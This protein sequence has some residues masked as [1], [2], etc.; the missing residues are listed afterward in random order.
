MKGSHYLIVLGVAAA[1]GTAVGL[2]SDRRNPAKG[3]LL[4]ASAGLVSGSV[5][6]GLYHYI[7][8]NAVPY[9][10]ARSPLYDDLD[11]I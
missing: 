6:A 8:G 3:G 4:G 5:A 11:A 10:G 7:T 2:L 1:V 9:Y